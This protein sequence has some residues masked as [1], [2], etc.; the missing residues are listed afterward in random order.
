MV[1][2]MVSA[3]IDLMIVYALTSIYMAHGMGMQ[4]LLYTALWSG[5]VLLAAST[6]ACLVPVIVKWALMGRFRTGERPLFSSF[7]WRNELADVFA[8]SLAVPSLVRLSVGSPL[9][10]AWV[11]LMGA[12]VQR[13]VWCETWWLPE[14]DLVTLE[15]GVSVNRG[16]VLQTH[17]FHDRIMRLEP[18][19]MRRGSTLGPNSFVL[20]GATIEERSTVGPGS[21]VMRQ[22]T[23]PANGN[24]GGNPIRHLE[25]GD[26]AV[27]AQVIP[28]PPVAGHDLPILSTAPTTTSQAVSAAAPEEATR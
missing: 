19:T 18:V 15:E 9:F 3:W 26:Q 22:E 23:V 1:P 16:T 13:G 8:E 27:S 11:R 28:G 10:N 17:L 6:L 20:P 4:G 2:A 25:A 12:R 14:F 21:L 5:A 24:W 7:V